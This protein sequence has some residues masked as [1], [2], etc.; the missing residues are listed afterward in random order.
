[1]HLLR[2]P[3]NWA[4]CAGGEQWG[5]GGARSG[6]RGPAGPPQGS[7]THHCGSVC[8]SSRTLWPWGL[9]RWDH[10]CC[11]LPWLHPAALRQ[12][13]LQK[14]A[15]DAGPGSSEQ[16]QGEG[17]WWARVGTRAI[18]R[19]HPMPHLSRPEVGG[20]WI[21]MVLQAALSH[22]PANSS[23]QKKCMLESLSTNTIYFGG[24]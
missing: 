22:I 12:N 11:Q 4:T 15:H 16:D 9:D 17:A 18:P 5:R 6:I 7:F 21:G 23:K 19:C 8:Y 1:M 24:S 14:R 10:F 20:E 13:S 2:G 3:W